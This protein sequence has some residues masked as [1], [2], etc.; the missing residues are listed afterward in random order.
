[1]ALDRTLRLGF[2]VCVARSPKEPIDVKML[3]G[4]NL[5]D[6]FRRRLAVVQAR[7]APPES[8]ESS[9]SPSKGGPERKL[10]EEDY[11]SL[12]L[13]G[14]LNPVVDSMRGLCA[15][16]KLDRVQQEICSRP[17]SLG[18][19]SEAQAVFDPDLLKEVFMELA[20]EVCS[21]E[22]KWGD[23]R[24]A[25]LAGKLKA[26]DGTLLP[27]LPRM[28][29]AL[30]QDESHR[31]AKLHLK[32]DLLHQAPCELK[33]TAGNI[34][35]R[36][37]LRAML[38]KGEIDVGD[39]YYGLEYGFFE[40]LRKAGVSFVI[41]IRNSPRFTLVEKLPL[42]DADRAAGV[43]WQGMVKLGEEGKWQGDPVRLVTV[44]VDG[45]TLQ[46]VTD[47]D[48]EAELIALIYRYRWQVELFFKWLKC[49]LGCRHLL[50][51]SSSGVTIQVYCALIG[52][53][54]LQMLTGRRPTKREM[55]LIQFYMVGMMG[56]D[57]LMS[58]LAEER[59][60]LQRLERLKQEREKNRL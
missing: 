32:F 10:L 41:R 40:E 16:S 26:V 49:I 38:K 14:L 31:A 7:M 35:E 58:L 47:L 59:D 56:P 45:H 17:V 11:F 60:R 46:I 54:M 39:R 51:E 28:L 15:A 5:I 34:C 43:T 19:F 12:F 24:L 48:I 30:W 57:E 23:P 18:S 6:D 42:S 27:A 52:A 55:E 37:A 4:W 8:S 44:E 2:A 36:K 3:S 21:G 50:A 29:W 20:T 25:P 53:L 22:A 13:F 9:E 33:L 1:M